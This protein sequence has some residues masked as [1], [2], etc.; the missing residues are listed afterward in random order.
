M[1]TSVILTE[2]VAASRTARVAGPASLP[3]SLPLPAAGAF[4]VHPVHPQTL[5]ACITPLQE[6]Q[7]TGRWWALWLLSQVLPS[8]PGHVGFDRGSALIPCLGFRVDPSFGAATL[9]T[10][11]RPGPRTQ[12]LCLALLSSSREPNPSLKVTTEA[13]S[14]CRFLPSPCTLPIECPSAKVLPI[15]RFPFSEVCP[16]LCFSSWILRC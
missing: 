1:Q 3:R 9:P 16:L 6:G 15:F 5:P 7:A 8:S 11:R 10:P 12:S 2:S 4:H 13:V 14:S